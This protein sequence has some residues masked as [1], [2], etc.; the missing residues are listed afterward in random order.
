VGLEALHLRTHQSLGGDSL[1]K[2]MACILVKDISDRSASNPTRI[3]SDNGR[4][5]HPRLSLENRLDLWF[6]TERVVHGIEADSRFNVMP[7]SAHCALTSPLGPLVISFYD[8]LSPSLLIFF[9][10]PDFDL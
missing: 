9:V 10:P 6:S 5:S 4:T 2:E 8:T 7:A 3:L 1:V